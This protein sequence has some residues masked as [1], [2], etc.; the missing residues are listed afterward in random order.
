MSEQKEKLL[1]ID[2]LTM[3]YQSQRR[4]FEKKKPSVKAV[5]DVSFEVYAGET[6][7]IVGESGCG[8]T[9]LGKCIVR[10]LKPA[11]GGMYFNDDGEMK[12]LLKLDR[13]NSFELRKK[14]QIVFQDPY[15]SLNPVHT[16]LEA[17]D[18]PMR[19]HG[20]GGGDKEKRKEIIA[21]AL[22]RVN[23]QP[24]YMYRYPH[25]FSGGQR[26]RICVAKALV[27]Q[28]KLIVCDEPVSAL[29]VSIQAQLLNL[30]RKLQKELGITFVFI[31]HDLSVV[32]YMSDR[33][34][35]MYLGNVVELA[36]ADELYNH[37]MHP[38]TEALLSAVP[39]PVYDA[40]KDRIVLTGDVPSPMN[41]PTG[42]PFHPRC[43]KC[44]EICKQVK[45]ELQ[46]KGVEG[47]YVA[48]HLFDKT[49]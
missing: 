43:T 24:E 14:L 11:S 30:M 17:F 47:H 1:V 13:K 21:E 18:E 48:C 26:Q 33:I 31:A 25:E 34:A 49:E 45:P 6:F 3:E 5:N 23:L 7:G 32:Q 4:L 20:I 12:D 9:T 36:D 2:H 41:P 19:V 27:L 29:D 8:K 44:M 22:K 40:K 35:V 38:Y 28:P 37:T 42:C 46:E 16:I 39:V 10:L 15:A